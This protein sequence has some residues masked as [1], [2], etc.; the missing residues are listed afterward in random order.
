MIYAH[1]NRNKCAHSSIWII[2]A[3]PQFIAGK[4]WN[5]LNT[6]STNDNILQHYYHFL[7]VLFFY[8]ILFY[9]ATAFQLEITWLAL[10]L[11]AAL[12]FIYSVYF[13]LFGGIIKVEWCTHNQTMY[14][15]IIG[16]TISTL[17]PAHAP[18]HFNITWVCPLLWRVASHLSTFHIISFHFLFFSSILCI[19][20]FSYRWKCAFILCPL[21][22]LESLSRSFDMSARV[23]YIMCELKR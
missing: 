6:F 16:I 3:R 2:S 12:F 7:F 17:S 19:L 10:H 5:M 15:V 4:C 21:Y 14:D 22:C 13:W 1:G 23:P 11:Y 8:I 18:L 9:D 20:W